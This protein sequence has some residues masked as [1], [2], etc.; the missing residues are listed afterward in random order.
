MAETGVD[1][2]GDCGRGVGFALF[3]CG[4]RSGGRATC[5]QDNLDVSCGGR[6]GERATC[7]PDLDGSCG[8]PRA[9]ADLDGSW[10]GFFCVEA[11]AGL[12][13]V[14]S[15]PGFITG[16]G[17]EE[18]IGVG[19]LSI[20]PKV[21]GGPWPMANLFR[22]A[23][24]LR[25]NITGESLSTLEPLR[26]L[27]RVLVATRRFADISSRATGSIRGPMV[28]IGAVGPAVLE[29]FVRLEPATDNPPG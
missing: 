25:P 13:Y 3:C 20:E 18:G 16:D 29:T 24:R 22:N 12:K 15:P 10:G 11:V 28:E 26:V 21:R 5:A 17:G 23:L 19:E 4:G 1:G 6:S 9:Q 2:A 7:F 8:G 27:R 14:I